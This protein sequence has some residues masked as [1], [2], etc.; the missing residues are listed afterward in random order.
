MDFNSS[1]N[2]FI[3]SIVLIIIGG[4]LSFIPK[5]KTNDDNIG[6]K[7]YIQV[8]IVLFS[9]GLFGLFIAFITKYKLGK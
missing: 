7:W 2:L 6:L 4:S 1:K 9:F 8:G 5:E 3:A